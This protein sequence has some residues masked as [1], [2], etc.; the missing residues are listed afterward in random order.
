MVAVPYLWLLVFFLL[1]FA[2]ILK[3][4]LADPIIARPPFTP[5]IDDGQPAQS[6][7]AVAKVSG[8]MRDLLTTERL[9]LN[10]IGR[11]SGIATMTRRYVD[12]VA[13]TTAGIYDTRKTTPGWR[14]LEKYAVRCG[15]ANNHRT[16]LFD[17]VL[18]NPS[19]FTASDGPLP[20]AIAAAGLPV[21]EVHASNPS[22]RGVRSSV[23]CQAQATTRHPPGFTNRSTASRNMKPNPCH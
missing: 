7:Q 10:L 11:L 9:V 15:G 20:D 21:Y 22:A 3:I 4:S 1:P 6:G 5:L 2:I 12:K 17:A 18:I 16:G 13:G 14:R 8:A 19:G 23:H